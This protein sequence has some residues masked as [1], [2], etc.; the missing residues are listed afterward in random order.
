MADWKN[1]LYYGDKLDILRRYIENES[2]DF[3]YLGPPLQT[4]KS[5]SVLFNEQ[6]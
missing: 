4:N 5:Y 2:V 3:V 1:R 6:H